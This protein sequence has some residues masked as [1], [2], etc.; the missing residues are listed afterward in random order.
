MG[1]DRDD[2]QTAMLPSKDMQWFKG[3]VEKRIPLTEIT[4]N[5][6]VSHDQHH[7]LVSYESKSPE[8]WALGEEL[9]TLTMRHELAL[10]SDTSGPARNNAFWGEPFFVGEGQGIIACAVNGDMH[11][12]RLDDGQHIHQLCIARLA[13]QIDGQPVYCFNSRS[14]D[15]IMATA[16]SAGAL[17]IW[18][19]R[20]RVAINRSGKTATANT[21][22]STAARLALGVPEHRL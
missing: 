17:K 10:P 15:D 11:F 8:V 20:P 1:K 4:M 16:T 22:E 6:G 21:N 3:H 18:G 19:P 2:K 13:E 5:F 14:K 9:R 12:W 7:M